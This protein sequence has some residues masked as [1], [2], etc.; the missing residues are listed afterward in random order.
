MVELGW[1]TYQHQFTNPSADRMIKRPTE[2][3]TV[4]I[5]GANATL[6][7]SSKFWNVGV[8]LVLQMHR[9]DASK[10]L[11]L[12]GHKIAQSTSAM[13]V[14]E[15]LTNSPKIYATSTYSF[16]FHLFFSCYFSGKPYYICSE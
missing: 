12:Y 7:L 3:H 14:A 9:R 4:E 1:N 5:S 8:M 16:L 6:K 13:N 10:L 15:K 11:N 2:T